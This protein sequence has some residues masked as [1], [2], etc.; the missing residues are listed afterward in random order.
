MPSCWVNTECS[1]HR[2]QHTPMIVCHPFILT[3]SSWPLN[4]ASAFSVPPYRSTTTSQFSIRAWRV[5]SPCHIPKVASWLTDEFSPGWPSIDRLQLLVQSPSIMASK[6][7]SKLARWQPPSASPNSL[8]HGLQLHLQT[9]SVTSSKCIS[10][11][12]HLQP[13]SSQDDGH[14]VHISKLAQSRPPSVSTNSVDY[15]LH[16]C[17]SRDAPSRPRSI[18][19]S[20]LHRHIEG[21]LELLSSTACSQSRYSVCR[22]AAI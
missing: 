21:H 11:L 13:A 9:R 1:I 19:L 12:A 10:R 16:K 8:H 18:S 20:S 2:V 7:I 17:I 4:V 6:C 5:K 15:G 14:E 3:I 22:W